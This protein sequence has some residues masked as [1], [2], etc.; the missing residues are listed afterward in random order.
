M[1]RPSEP[2]N[3]EERDL[4]Q[5]LARMGGPHEP[6]PALDAIIL[7]AA[8]AAVSEPLAHVADTPADPKISPLR[9][10]RPGPRWPLGFGLAASL[11]LAAGIGWRLQGDGEGSSAESAAQAPAAQAD[12]VTQAVLLEPPLQRTPPPP[13]PPLADASTDAAARRTEVPRD[14]LA[15]AAPEPSE[16]EFVADMAAE[17]ATIAESAPSSPPPPAG[18]TKNA[19]ADDAALDEVSVTGSRVAAEHAVGAAEYTRTPL[20]ERREQA[21]SQSAGKPAVTASPAS[22]SSSIQNERTRGLA[23]GTEGDAEASKSRGQSRFDERP[24]VS[25]DSAEFRQ[26]WL[27][28]IRRLIA[29]G[30]QDDARSS[31]QEFRRRYPDMELP[32]DLRKLA[33][34]L[35][36]P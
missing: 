17:A 34:T 35:P 8:R 15:K 20:N 18:A 28:R 29:K 11:V 24:P 16:P 12:E 26:A 22:T 27:Q 5:R 32:D 9:P 3:A 14:A 6:A 30:A 4:A 31:L 23:S 13:P 25:A 21:V 2:F 36:A 1:N 10:R 7:A 33:A 19:V